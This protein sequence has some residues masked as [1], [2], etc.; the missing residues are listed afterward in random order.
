MTEEGIE[1]IE[2]AAMITIGVEGG[3]EAVNAD[4][5]VQ[6]L[7]TGESGRCISFLVYNFAL[8]LGTNK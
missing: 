7:D 3:T 8:E 2:G 1:A 6:D 4:V 5:P